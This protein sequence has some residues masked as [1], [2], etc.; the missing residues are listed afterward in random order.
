[1]RSNIVEIVP[2]RPE[3]VIKGM[4]DGWMV[5]DKNNRIIDLNPAAETILGVSYQEVYEKSI[6]SI[7]PDWSELWTSTNGIKEL[8]I[9]RSWRGN[10]EWRYL[11][12]RASIL[13][14][15]QNRSFG[16]LIV[17]RDITDRKQVEDARQRARD[18]MFIILN[19]I[20]NAASRSMDFQEF[21]RESLYH[22]I[23][24]F[25]SEVLVVLL[26][27]EQEKKEGFG[28]LRLASHFGLPIPSGDNLH[29]F[30][31]PDSAF[32]EV[33]DSGKPVIYENAYEDAKVPKF[34]RKLN[35]NSMVV[36]PMMAETGDSPNILGVLILG[37]KTG[38]RY[39]NDE[40]IRLKAIVEH[41][42]ILID[43]ERRRQI[44]IAFSER[45]RLMRD[46]H[47][48]VSQK[49]YGL[50]TLTEAAQAGLEAG[51]KVSLSDF[52]KKIGEGARQAVKEMR[53]FLFEMQPVN[54]EKEGL[55]SILHHRLAAVEGRADIQARLLADD[56]IA[57]SKDKEIV[58]YY[59][60][61]EALNN[62]L[63]H[64]HAKSVFVTIKQTRNNVMLEIVDD[65][66]GFDMKKVNKGGLGLQNM[67]ARAA[68]IDGKLKINTKPGSGAKIILTV[69]RDKTRS[70]GRRLSS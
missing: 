69:N 5:L 15:I 27:D 7:L 35:I 40:L 31:V 56:K 62:V 29:D 34:L 45:E 25:Q 23:Y 19:A 4:S 9:R 26:I 42:T 14:D 36:L 50:V 16:Q 3:T 28:I 6:Q 68:Q 10:D 20:S 44:A 48:S 17:W 67:K 58:F 37:R 24:P 2:I 46:L 51:S 60:A 57:L 13:K 49:L 21:L 11:N 12:V 54:L 32:A 70:F 66:R 52:L 33:F 18:E 55:V 22:L 39:V 64:A 61:Q 8:E 38:I 41:I 30:S 63:K 65:G 59:I 47:D 1:L 53:L 43:N